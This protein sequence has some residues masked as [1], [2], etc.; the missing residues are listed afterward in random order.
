MEVRI[1][2]YYDQRSDEE[3]REESLWGDFATREFLA[4]ETARAFCL[5]KVPL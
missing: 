2:R 1:A 5:R 3:R 4:A